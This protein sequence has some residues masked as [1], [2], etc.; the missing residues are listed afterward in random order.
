MNSKI[1]AEYGQDKPEYIRTRRIPNDYHI[2]ISNSKLLYY[3][4]KDIDTA[5]SEPLTHD[6]MVI[7]D[8]IDGYC[9][10]N[11]R[12][13]KHTYFDLNIITREFYGLAD[14]VTPTPKQLQSVFG[15]IDILM[16]TH[17]ITKNSKGEP[18]TRALLYIEMTVKALQGRI[19][20]TYDMTGY[21]GLN[22]YAKAH[23]IK[24]TRIQ[25]EYIKIPKGMTGTLRNA[26]LNYMIIQITNEKQEILQYDDFYSAADATD[27]KD[28][29][30][31]HD[32]RDKIHRIL[33]SCIDRGALKSYKPFIE[34]ESIQQQ[35]TGLYLNY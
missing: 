29:K 22:E 26:L 34:N 31:R 19:S 6:H 13:D 16:H 14:T 3:I 1:S 25:R 32:I 12:K 20:P 11:M 5:L 21:S 9:C 30:A 8:I 33:D 4:D 15:M 28:R 35:P 24:A 7:V 17:I 2:S 10:V 23:R 18:T 27:P